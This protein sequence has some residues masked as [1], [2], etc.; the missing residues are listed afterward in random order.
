MHIAVM[1]GTF[2]PVHNGHLRGAEV[3]FELIRPDRFLFM[4]TFVT[5]HKVGEVGVSAEARLEMLALAT[6]GNPAFEV[7]RME[8]ERGGRSFTVDTLRELKSGE[9]DI[10]V[11]LVMGSDSFNE[12]TS[13]HDYKEI[14]RLA[15]IVVI[16]RPGHSPGELSGVLPVELASD[17]CYDDECG[18]YRNSRGNS[19]TFLDLELP[20]IS[21]SVVRRLVGEGGSIDSLVPVEVE[22][23][24]KA[25]GLY[26]E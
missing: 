18:N 10:K 4:P 21:S 23:Y 11:S 26:R 15:S 13:W 24:I 3:V 25:S 7:S 8:I 9:S 1:G 12:I 2:N 20:D 22:E 17:F 5:P 16:P 19:I 14:F 6:E